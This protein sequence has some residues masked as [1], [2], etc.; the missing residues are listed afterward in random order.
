MR[1]L[2]H[3]RPGLSPGW[4]AF[5]LAL[6]AWSAGAEVRVERLPDGRRVVRNL[7]AATPRASAPA[8]GAQAAPASTPPATAAPSRPPVPPDE[9]R[10]LVA[11]AAARE[12][13]DRR[14]VEAVVRAESAWNPAALS[15]KGAIGLMQL[16][17]ATAAGL[18]VAD[19]W[20][21]AENVRGGV[22]Y[23]RMLIDRFGRLEHAV[24]A[25]NAGP[26][27]VERHGGVPPYAETRAYVRRVLALY[28]G[29]EADLGARVGARGAA[30]RLVQAADGRRMLTNAA[31]AA[32]ATLPHAI[33]VAQAPPPAAGAGESAAPATLGGAAAAATVAATLAAR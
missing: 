20:D 13:V 18:T 11:E 24:A 16:M 27:A 8:A 4:A 33:V 1:P 21:A 31:G 29:R 3:G 12:G 17:P 22:R 30:P 5:A 25:Y 26:G 23:L 9:L 6:L 7:P 32:P 15:R 28:D 14:L 2:E 10:R 19:P